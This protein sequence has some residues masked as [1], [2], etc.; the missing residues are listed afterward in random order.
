MPTP[1][2]T[3]GAPVPSPTPRPKPTPPKVTARP[4]AAKPTRRPST[5]ELFWTCCRTRCRQGFHGGIW[6]PHWLCQQQQCRTSSQCAFIT[7]LETGMLAM[8]R[9]RSRGRHK[10]MA[11]GDM[12][13]PAHTAHAS[14]NVLPCS[15]RQA[16]GVLLRA[17]LVPQGG[18][19]CDR[20]H[21][22]GA[23]RDLCDAAKPNLHHVWAPESST[24]SD[25]DCMAHVT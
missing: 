10:C 16:A 20:R 21:E 2:P 17:A 15:V 5:G 8:C 19:D 11:L 3:N 7:P 13:P 4:A 6:L 24:C 25:G 1:E 23:L 14:S 22:S 18:Q 12:C 9:W